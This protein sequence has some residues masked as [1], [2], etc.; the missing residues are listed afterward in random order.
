MK[1]RRL[2]LRGADV[3]LGAA[4]L[5][6]RIITGAARIPEPGIEAPICALMTKRSSIVGWKRLR[7]W[8]G[9]TRPS[10]ARLRRWRA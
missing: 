6:L 4:S 9:A 5:G 1:R 8:S 3:V 7:R 10:E 2:L